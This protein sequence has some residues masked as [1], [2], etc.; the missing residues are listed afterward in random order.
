MIIPLRLSCTSVLTVSSFK[1]FSKGHQWGEPLISG[2]RGLETALKDLVCF[3]MCDI[4][5]LSGII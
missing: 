2:P 3:F 5:L 4:F 1:S